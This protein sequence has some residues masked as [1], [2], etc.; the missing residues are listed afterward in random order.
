[1]QEDVKLER[2]NSAEKGLG[3][4]K[5]KHKQRTT[6]SSAHVCDHVSVYTWLFLGCLG[7]VGTASTAAAA[8]EAAG[9]TAAEAVAE[10]EKISSAAVGAEH[11]VA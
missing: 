4:F 11:V 8:A 10:K 2:V 9:A 6:C 3:D 7:F 5:N 1:M